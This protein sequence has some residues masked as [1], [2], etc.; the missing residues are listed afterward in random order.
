MRREDRPTENPVTIILE[1]ERV[2]SH[3]IPREDVP[4]RPTDDLERSI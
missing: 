1:G 3:A 4:E 2:S